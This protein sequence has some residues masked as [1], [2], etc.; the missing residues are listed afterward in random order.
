MHFPYQQ[1]LKQNLSRLLNLYNLDQFSDSYGVGDRLYAG[2]KILDFA[3]GTLQ[4]GIHSL[5]IAQHLGLLQGC[6]RIAQWIDAAIQAIPRVTS[7]KGSAAEAYP[8][9]HSF[10]VTALVAFDALATIHLMQERISKDRKIKYL[11]VVKPLI[12]FLKKNDEEHAIISNHLAT[13]VA[14]LVLWNELSNEGSHRYQ[15]FLKLILKHQSREGWYREYE[16]AD[17]G[18]QSLCLY[19]LCVA[20]RFLDDEALSRSISRSVD[21]LSYFIHPDGSIGG[22]YGSRNTEVFYPGGLMLLSKENDLCAR[23]IQEHKKS[24]DEGVH[25]LPQD[26][27]IGNFVPLLNSYAYAALF[28]DSTFSDE[29]TVLLPHERIFDKQFPDAGIYI[30]STSQYYAI[31]NYKKGGTIKIFDKK[32]GKLDVEDGGLTGKLRNGIKFSTQSFDDSQDFRDL[33]IRA[34]FIRINEA[35]PGPFHF[36]ILRMLAITVFSSVFLG[37]VFKR[38]IVKRLMTGKK[39][40]RGYA[41]RKFI[42]SEEKI[43]VRE[44]VHPNSMTSYCKRGGKFRAIHMASSG[45]NTMHEYSSYPAKYLDILDADAE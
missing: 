26:I 8:N 25:I 15:H 10:C 11:D 7:G 20:N 12:D 3:N 23:L 13:A 28:E 45:Y 34:A 1:I 27:D 31:L 21:F 43:T 22:L 35:Y 39:K 42:F 29:S 33:T 32:S 4:G 44:L 40:V 5:A 38:L 18:Y 2:W 17:P 37:N 9:E 19:Y 41:I 36:L 6:D 14:A 16:G 30:K 24:M